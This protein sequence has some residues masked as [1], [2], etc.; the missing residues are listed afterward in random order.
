MRKHV[1]LVIFTLVFSTMAFAQKPWKDIWK[2][3]KNSSLS[4]TTRQAKPQEDQDSSLN[5]DA[6]PIYAIKINANQLRNRDFNNREKAAIRRG[7]S[8]KT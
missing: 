6:E 2:N 1:A 4:K 5:R 8:K 3:V 7:Y